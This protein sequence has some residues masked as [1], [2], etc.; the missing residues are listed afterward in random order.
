MCVP[1]TSRN[2]YAASGYFN[3]N[4]M[5]KKSW[6]M[7]ETFSYGYSSEGT[8]QELSNEYQH[9]RVQMVF[10]NIFILVLWTKLVSALK[11]LKFN[12]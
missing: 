8:L 9:D 7:T 10:K 4:K 6:N 2:P 3:Q 1:E 5:M 12:T 11:G